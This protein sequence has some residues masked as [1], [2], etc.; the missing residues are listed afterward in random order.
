MVGYQELIVIFL[1]VLLLFGGRKIP[2]I[3]RG[4]GKGIR[5][6]RK[7]KDD[8]RDAIE[9]EDEAVAARDGPSPSPSTPGGASSGDSQPGGGPA[10]EPGCEAPP[11]LR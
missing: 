6:F 8:I 10:A 5:E 1:L 3:A 7:A 11:A 2:E 9:R 4:L